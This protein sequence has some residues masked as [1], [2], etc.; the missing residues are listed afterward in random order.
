MEM[1]FV[2]RNRQETPVVFSKNML[3]YLVFQWS[4]CTYMERYL[5]S[6]LIES[7]FRNLK[8]RN[9]VLQLESQ[10]KIKIAKKPSLKLS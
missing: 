5:F 2:S 1:Q 6:Y 9:P 10:E 7:Y 8:H 4:M 3:Q